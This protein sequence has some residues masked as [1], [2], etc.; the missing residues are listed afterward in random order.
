LVLPSGIA[1]ASIRRATAVAERSGVKANA[2]QAAVVGTPARSMLSLIAKGS[3]QSGLAA[4]SKG[5]S[6]SSARLLASGARLMN[7]PG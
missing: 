3:P 5:P 7:T 1:P 2:G 6:A 4:G